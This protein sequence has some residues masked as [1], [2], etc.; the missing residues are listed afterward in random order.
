MNGQRA[1]QQRT[2]YI[3]INNDVPFLAHLVD[4]SFKFI[5]FAEGLILLR[6]KLIFNF[7]AKIEILKKVFLI[8]IFQNIDLPRGLINHNNDC[9]INSLLQ[10]LA[11]SDIVTKWLNESISNQSPQDPSIN[12]F[13]TLANIF[14]KI[15]RE[16]NTVD[17]NN[18][19]IHNFD[20]DQQEFYAAQD[21]KKA[22]NAHNWLI[23]SEEHDCH[24]LF[25]V[26][27]DVLDEESLESKK[28]LRSLN[29]FSSFKRDNVKTKLK[30]PFL[31]YLIVQLQCLDCNY[32]VTI[33]F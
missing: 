21:L 17:L 10:S 29:Y 20:Y 32:K 8:K 19:L 16:E 18:K 22:L 1:M 12:L 6:N 5:L 2:I 26:L 30:N 9:F 33:L 15:N 7:Y 31:G 13:D 14:T 4:Y 25:H 3:E 11:A 24:E 23:Q 28:Y 27:M